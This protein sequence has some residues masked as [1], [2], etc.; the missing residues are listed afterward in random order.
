MKRNRRYSP[1]GE[2]SDT[3]SLV[4]EEPVGK[5]LKEDNSS[6]REEEEV[7]DKKLDSSRS[8]R[9]NGRTK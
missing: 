3:E 8:A 1:S 2:L 4:Q 9:K 5:Q 7:D 6:E